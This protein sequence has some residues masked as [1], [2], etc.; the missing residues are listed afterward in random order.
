MEIESYTMNIT[1]LQVRVA[2]VGLR[3]CGGC[4]GCG[5]CEAVRVTACMLGG[6]SCAHEIHTDMTGTAR[7]AGIH[8]CP[9]PPSPNRAC[10]HLSPHASPLPD[11]QPPRNITPPPP[12]APPPATTRLAT[13]CILLIQSLPPSPSTGL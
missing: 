9:P 5:G 7:A 8:M 12:P 11:P 4:G 2:A 1:T 3:G 6:A 13:T 10:R